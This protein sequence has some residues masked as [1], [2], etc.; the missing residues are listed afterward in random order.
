GW[1]PRSNRSR[2]RAYPPRRR[3]G[4]G[5]A[6][7]CGSGCGSSPGRRRARRKPGRRCAAERS[8]PGRR[9]PR[10]DSP[11]RARSTGSIEPT[12]YHSSGS[13]P[14]RPRTGHVHV[15]Q[16]VQQ[17]DPLPPQ[18]ERFLLPDPLVHEVHQLELV[19]DPGELVLDGLGDDR[20]PSVDDPLLG[21]VIQKGALEPPRARDDAVELLLL[22]EPGGRGG[23]AEPRRQHHR[24]R[25]RRREA[26]P[27]QREEPDLTPPALSPG[28]DLQLREPVPARPECGEGAQPGH[29]LVEPLELGAAEL[30]HLRVIPPPLHPG[31]LARLA[32]GEQLVHGQVGHAGTSSPSH[33]RSRVWA[34][35][36]W[37][38]EKLTVFCIIAAISSWV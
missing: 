4:P 16:G 38:F 13:E 26:E 31:L 22:V 33:R 34:R 24:E 1:W 9:G 2:S 20:R 7:W 35:A 11:R 23:R 18:A 36:S 15:D 30:A 21:V 25:H 8:A 19:V 17:P 37:D 10:G 27:R 14:H 28:P 32:Q 12:W 3:A 6:R 5:A 29:A